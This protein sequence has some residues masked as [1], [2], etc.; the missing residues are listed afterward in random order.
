[1]SFRTWLYVLARHAAV[2]WESTPANQ[3]ARRAGVSELSAVAERVRSA[4][5]PFL[6]TSFRDGVDA[7]RRELDPE[8]RTLLIL[9]VNRGLDW[10]DVARV[11]HD[12]ATPLEGEPLSRASARARQRFASVKRRLRE[13]AKEV[14][15][16][17]R[18]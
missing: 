10:T 16:L 17:D 2:R 7:L 14:G 1:C 11:L 18:D 15:L 12:E 9:R 5:A 4:T 6:R 13:R 8:E 3:D